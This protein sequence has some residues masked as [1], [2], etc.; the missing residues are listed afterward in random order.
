MPTEQAMKAGAKAWDIA[1]SAFECSEECMPMGDDCAECKQGTIVEF[2]EAFDE[3][4]G[5]PELIKACE[6]VMNMYR[7]ANPITGS[8]QW[9]KLDG[10][11]RIL[12][13]ALA[14]HGEA[15]ENT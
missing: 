12:G 6:K 10:L 3:A 11:P 14:K 2:A 7:H 8:G 15:Y 9:E 4:T 1:K 13:K 5:L